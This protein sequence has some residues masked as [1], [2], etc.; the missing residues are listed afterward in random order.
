MSK[1]KPKKVICSKCKQRF[2]DRFDL[3]L[4]VAKEHKVHVPYHELLTENDNWG[5]TYNSKKEANAFRKNPSD[6]AL[7]CAYLE[8][9]LR[10]LHQIKE[11]VEKERTIK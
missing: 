10:E 8:A 2:V 7:I 1:I 9:L 6:F 3:K 4:H 5:Y 11:A